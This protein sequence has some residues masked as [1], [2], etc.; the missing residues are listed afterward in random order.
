MN[1]NDK[2]IKRAKL[3]LKVGL[4]LIILVGLII[5]IYFVM[6]NPINRKDDATNI[7]ESQKTYTNEELIGQWPLD[8]IPCSERA[9]PDFKPV[10]KFIDCEADEY[11]RLLYTSVCL[12]C[13]GGMIYKCDYKDSFYVTDIEQRSDI[14]DSVVAITKEYIVDKVGKIEFDA[15]YL[16]DSEKSY[17]DGGA[18]SP[19][20]Y[21]IY[22]EYQ[23]VSYIIGETKYLKSYV[24]NNRVSRMKG[25][26][27]CDT[28]PCN[29][30]IDKETAINIASDNGF[31]NNDNQW[32]S[33]NLRYSYNKFDYWVWAL[34]KKIPHVDKYCEKNAIIEINAN[35]G[36]ISDISEVDNCIVI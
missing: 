23:P 6:I 14:P 32:F 10:G 19:I 18:S 5:A 26:Y 12:N 25:V 15:N 33:I 2:A 31:L 20:D 16:Y 17:K 28:P 34:S 27:A 30:N 8:I 11:C 36:E 9:T 3:Q 22:Y 35:T 13:G 29:I 4:L 1:K 7:S 21:V 24:V